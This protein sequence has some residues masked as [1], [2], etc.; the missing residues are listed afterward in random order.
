MLKMLNIKKLNKNIPSFMI[1]WGYK[2]NQINVTLIVHSF[3]KIVKN[4]LSDLP[5][6]D[7]PVLNIRLFVSY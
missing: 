3:L 5:K 4:I 7:C 1:F 6:N 2:T